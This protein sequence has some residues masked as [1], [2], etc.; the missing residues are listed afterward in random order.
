MTIFSAV[1]VIAYDNWEVFLLPER[2]EECGEEKI[3]AEG[4]LRWK[5]LEREEQEGIVGHKSS[6][7]EGCVGREEGESS[8]T[9]PPKSRGCLLSITL[10]TIQGRKNKVDT[11]TLNTTKRAS[12]RTLRSRSLLNFNASSCALY[13]VFLNFLQAWDSKTWKRFW[14]PIQSRIEVSPVH[15]P[16]DALLAVSRVASGTASGHSL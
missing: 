15:W 1:F 3:S 16:H 11:V 6:I 5:Y 7:R 8:L 4:L 2:E 13:N 10:L 9:A 12:S 14:A